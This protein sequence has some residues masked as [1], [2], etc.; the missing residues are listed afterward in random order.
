ML[1]SIKSLYKA[2]VIYCNIFLLNYGKE[3]ESLNKQNLN[4]KFGEDILIMN[5]ESFIRI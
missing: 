4:E 3:V 2:I 1:S 5:E